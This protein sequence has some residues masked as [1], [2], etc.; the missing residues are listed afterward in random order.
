M[1][2]NNVVVD[3]FIAACWACV[4]VQTYINPRL[5]FVLDSLSTVTALFYLAGVTFCDGLFDAVRSTSAPPLSWFESLS[6]IIPPNVWGIY[7][8]VLKKAG[9]D[10]LLY[11]GSGTATYRGVRVRIREHRERILSPVNVK[12][13]LEF[14]YDIT[15]IALL[16]HC[17]IPS[18]ANIPKIR[19][20]W[21]ALEAV[22]TAVFWALVP[23]EKNFGLAHMC[24]WDES[25]FEWLGIC[26]HNPLHEAIRCREDELDFT[27]EQHRSTC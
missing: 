14:G 11:I 26:T 23:S 27:P 8:L 6:P 19:T 9:Y 5:R 2:T 18:P 1:S 7:V 15:H 13:A 21:V 25:T 24:P 17:D 22:L 16:A 20:L 3:L 12:K 10:P 4:N